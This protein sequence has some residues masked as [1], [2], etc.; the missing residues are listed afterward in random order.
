MILANTTLV[1]SVKP[2][3]NKFESLVLEQ[4]ALQEFLN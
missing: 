4:K 1:T 2:Q 3:D